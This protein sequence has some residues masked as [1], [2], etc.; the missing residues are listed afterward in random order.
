MAPDALSRGRIIVPGTP[1]QL[2]TCGLFPPSSAQRR[3]VAAAGHVLDAKACAPGLLWFSF[4]Q[5]CAPG[6]TADAVRELA[7]KHDLWVVDDVPAPGQAAAG[8][9]PDAAWPLLAE[10][11]AELAARDATLFLV[12][13][14]A[15]D[16][17]GAARAAADPAVRTGLGRLGRMLA[18]LPLMESD[19]RAAVE[20][21]SGS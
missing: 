1:R 8:M 13:H 11:A 21:I 14:E 9:D 18:G 6:V 15:P 12:A 7:A 3:P 4:A 17:F 16:W 20:G 5:L 19:E 10:M 2:G